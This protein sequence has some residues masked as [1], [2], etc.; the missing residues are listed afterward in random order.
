M[1]RVEIAAKYGIKQACFVP[2]E[3]GV[4]EFNSDEAKWTDIPQVNPKWI[5]RRFRPCTQLSTLT[6]Q[7]SPCHA[8][9][10]HPGPDHAQVSDAQGFR[11]PRGVLLPLLATQW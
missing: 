10:N 5:S 6:S 1:R 3:L 11:D 7:P 4:L 2:F 8:N 9:P